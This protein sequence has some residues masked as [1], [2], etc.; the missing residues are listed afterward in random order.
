[1]NLNRYF[2]SLWQRTRQN[3][4]K[5]QVGV[6]A[7][8]GVALG[9]AVLTVPSTIFGYP[10]QGLLFG[11]LLKFGKILF[12]LSVAALAAIGA[13]WLPRLR[14]SMWANKLAHSAANRMCALTLNAA[15]LLAGVSSV[16]L[17]CHEGHAFSV[18]FNGAIWLLALRQFVI[19]QASG[20][21]RTNVTAACTGWMVGVSFQTNIG[22]FMAIAMHHI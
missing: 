11:I 5:R 8:V 9:L 22:H 3:K 2:K 16:V 4:A 15:A 7:L 18:F 13:Q 20:A 6:S 1:M 14:S 19:E 17:F 21:P 10:W 12:L